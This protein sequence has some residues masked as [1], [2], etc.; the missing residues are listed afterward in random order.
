[1]SVRFE[2]IFEHKRD[3]TKPTVPLTASE[4]NFWSKRC[5][6][7]ILLHLVLNRPTV[8]LFRARTRKTAAPPATDPQSPLRLDTRHKY[9]SSTSPSDLILDDL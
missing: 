9:Y 8:A 1:M 2:T 4:S 6:F 7:S 3:E 5:V